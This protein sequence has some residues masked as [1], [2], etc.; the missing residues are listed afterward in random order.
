MLRAGLGVAGVEVSGA[1]GRGKVT[2]CRHVTRQC[3][4]VRHS[5]DMGN[6]G[7]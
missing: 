1:I 5:Y 7:G 2:S 4:S 3:R 6:A